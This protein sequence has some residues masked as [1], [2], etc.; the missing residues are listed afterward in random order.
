MS[1]IIVAKA[2]KATPPINANPL[3]TTCDQ[4]PE[5]GWIEERF[6]AIG[7]DFAEAGGRRRELI[8]IRH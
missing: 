1:R 5:K 7:L 8:A 4:R 6:H 3:V 2:A